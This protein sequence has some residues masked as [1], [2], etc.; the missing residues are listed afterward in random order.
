MKDLIR[1]ILFEYLLSER[2]FWDLE[3]VEQ[4]AKKYNR[5]Q[6]FRTQD[7][8]AFQWAK[9]QGVLNQ[10][11][12]HMKR[13]RLPITREQILDLLKGYTNLSDFIR[14]YPNEYR[15]A[16]YHNWE[17]LFD[18]LERDRE[19]WTPEKI[20][21]LAKKYQFPS[22]FKKNEPNAYDSAGRLGIY[23]DV[24]SHMKRKHETWT[25]EKI[26]D[27]SEPY[28]QEKDFQKDFPQAVA[29]AKR[30]GIWSQIKEKLTPSYKNWTYDEVAKIA[31]KYHKKNDFRNLDSGAYGAASYHGWLDD[32]TQ[33]MDDAY[34]TWTKEKVWSEAQ[35]YNSRSE[36][37]MNSKAAYQAAK[38]HGWYDEVTSH[39]EYQGNLY[40]RM[41]YA[42]EFPDKSVY[43]GL[44]HDKDERERQHKTKEKSAVYQ[45]IKSTELI[46]TFKMISNN[47]INYKLA[48]ELEGCTI[49]KYKSEGWKILNV[50]K[51]GG[52]GSRCI[53][54]LTFDEVLSKA[55]NF[56]KKSDFQKSYPREYRVAKQNGWLDEVTKH[57][58]IYKIKRTP[59]NLST[60]MSMYNSETELRKKDPSTHQAAFRI[61]GNQFIKDFYK[62]IK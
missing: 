42:Y 59:E 53:T 40:N 27:I 41:V 29:A 49:E 43:V 35:K 2:T 37:G 26:F 33:H 31:R 34:E 5:L 56:E 16:K 54:V 61:L 25:K 38:S 14:D 50:R 47:Y 44:T 10:I 19:V 23:Q 58:K 9:K 3:K 15:R 11:T 7:Y 22:D 17:D 20:R 4:V 46:P 57:M 39:M 48:Q 45:Y 62:K 13:D 60:I 51:A 18:A 12:S 28:T 36:F 55:K 8:N 30:L 24:T 6:D 1:N 32:V 21:D 52:L